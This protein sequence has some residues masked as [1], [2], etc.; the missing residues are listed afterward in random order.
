MSH[1]QPW[2]EMWICT[3]GGLCREQTLNS[4][5]DFLGNPQQWPL[6]Y[7]SKPTAVKHW[8]SLSDI[9]ASRLEEVWRSCCTVH[10]ISCTFSR[11]GLVNHS[12]G[13]RFGEFVTEFHAC[14]LLK[15]ELYSKLAHARFHKNT[16]NAGP[17]VDNTSRSTLTHEIYCY[18]EMGMFT[19]C[20][21]V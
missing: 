7:F 21:H 11:V 9:R 14:S 1:C 6:K 5:S 16:C 4:V 18:M 2:I 3:F 20:T 17:D 8:H 13:C 15:F 12:K 19:T 10:S